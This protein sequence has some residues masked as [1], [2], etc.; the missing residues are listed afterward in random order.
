MGFWDG[1]RKAVFNG[2]LVM[3]FRW[4]WYALVL[5]LAHAIVYDHL[6]VERTNLIGVMSIVVMALYVIGSYVND[7]YEQKGVTT[8]VITKAKSLYTSKSPRVV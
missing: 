7:W 3:V 6:H 2:I 5:C 1:T 8:K 4:T